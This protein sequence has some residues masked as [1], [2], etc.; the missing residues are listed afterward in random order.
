MSFPNRLPTGSYEGT[1]DGVTIKWGPNAITHLPDDAKVFNVDQA[2]L[3]GA[4]EHIAHASAKRLGKTGVR[5]LGSFHNTTTVTATGEKQPDQCHCS[6]SMTPG[7]AK[8]HIYVDL[9]DEA[10]LNNMKVLGESVVPPGKST[11]DP[12]LSIGTYPQ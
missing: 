6:V 10:S 5:I 12:S 1:I 3:K 7:Q 9:G 2:A 8:V 4:T 11:P